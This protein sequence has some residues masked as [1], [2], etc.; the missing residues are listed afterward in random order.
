MNTGNIAGSVHC[1][2]VKRSLSPE[3]QR[4]LSDLHMHLRNT[5]ILNLWW[6]LSTSDHHVNIGAQST[7]ARCKTNIA[8]DEIDLSLII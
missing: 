4:V 5:R 2:Q 6:Y 1:L 3:T 7:T 8:D